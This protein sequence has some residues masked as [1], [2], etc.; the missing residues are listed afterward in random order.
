MEKIL[1][2]YNADS[3]FLNGIKDLVHKNISPATYGCRLCALTYNNLGMVSEWKHFWKGLGKTVEFLHRDELEKL[4]KLKEVPL[5]AAFIH[6]QTGGTR[7]WL[8]AEAMNSCATLEDLKQLVRQ[9]LT[10]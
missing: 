3:G 2:V 7:L 1:F 6:C 4:Y 8:D 10:T 5:P 9:S